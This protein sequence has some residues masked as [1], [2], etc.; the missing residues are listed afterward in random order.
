MW[1]A[2]RKVIEADLPKPFWAHIMP[3]YALDTRHGAT[4]FDVFLSVFPSWFGL[5]SPFYSSISPFWNVNAYS[6]PLYV[7]IA[8]SLRVDFGLRYLSNDWIITVIWNSWRW[9][10]C[11]LHWDGHEC[12]AMVWI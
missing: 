10:K 12:N 3:L 8:L 1:A 4:E 2:A 7:G 9:T 11:I 5:I 6:V